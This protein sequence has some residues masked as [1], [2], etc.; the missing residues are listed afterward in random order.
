ML[1]EAD[2]VRRFL[3][4][5]LSSPLPDDT[6]IPNFRNLPERQ[7][8]GLGLLEEIK[9]HLESQ[10]LELQE[11]IIVDTTSIEAP[12]SIRTGLGRGTQRCIRSRRG[13]SGDS[14]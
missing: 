4:L 3:M 13:T 1:Y 8:P 11:V 12:S 14:G 7:N 5:K 10:G 6:T 2:P 9:A